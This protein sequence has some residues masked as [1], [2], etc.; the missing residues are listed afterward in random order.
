[1]THY[2][3]PYVVFTFYNLNLYVI[4]FVITKFAYLT[5]TFLTYLKLPI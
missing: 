3:W 2:L 1:M 4:L 5:F